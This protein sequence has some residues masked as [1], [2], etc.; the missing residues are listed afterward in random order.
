MNERIV[1]I[2]FRY[3]LGRMTYVVSEVVD[4]LLNNWND[5]SIEY[6]EKII[7]E[8]NEAFETNNYGHSIDK[9]QWEKIL[10]QYKNGR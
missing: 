7:K 4:Y 3:A 6:Q 5:I 1:F 8:I 9:D 2:A 10:K